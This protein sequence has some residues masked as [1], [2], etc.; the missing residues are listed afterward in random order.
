MPGAVCWHFF[1]GPLH[2]LTHPDINPFP[3]LKA[4]YEAL[5]W[6][7]MERIHRV[8]VNGLYLSPLS[9]GNI[10]MYQAY[11]DE[12]EASHSA[13]S[14]YGRALAEQSEEAPVLPIGHLVDLNHWGVLQVCILQCEPFTRAHDEAHLAYDSGRFMRQYACPDRGSLV[15]ALAAALF[16]YAYGCHTYVEMGPAKAITAQA[17]EVIEYAVHVFLT[18]R[19]RET[20]LTDPRLKGIHSHTVIEAFATLTSLVQRLAPEDYTEITP[21]DLRTFRKSGLMSLLNHAEAAQLGMALRPQEDIIGPMRMGQHLDWLSQLSRRPHWRDA[22]KDRLI[23]SLYQA[24][25]RHGPVTYPKSA[26]FE[27]MA[28]ILLMAGLED[29]DIM[30]ISDIMALA[31]RLRKRIAVLPF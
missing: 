18:L 17:L 23:V 10:E 30:D 5:P 12:L 6:S 2:Y 21:A 15:D 7:W 8:T 19:Q 29:G 31:E 20:V 11:M 3:R 25:F 4:F 13:Y 14:G 22:L 16:E 28:E 1:Q 24:L 27:A 26:R 9:S